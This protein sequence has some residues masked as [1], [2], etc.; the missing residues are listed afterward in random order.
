MIR[1]TDQ[2]FTYKD[3]RYPEGTKVRFKYETR[4]E[5][6]F[7]PDYFGNGSVDATFVGTCHGDT[8]MTDWKFEYINSS[9]ESREMIMGHYQ[10]EEF[11]EEIVEIPEDFTEWFEKENH[12]GKYEKSGNKGCIIGL[13]VCVL[14]FLGLIYAMVEID[15]LFNALTLLAIIIIVVSVFLGL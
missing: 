15:W 9:G 2:Y 1:Y 10:I 3:L 5:S 12:I 6:F 4:Y 14:L 13:I 11:L 8:M 7:E